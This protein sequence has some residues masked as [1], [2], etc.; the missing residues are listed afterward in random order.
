VSDHTD[1]LGPRLH[2]A[3]DPMLP[4]SEAEQRLLR[5][6]RAR[7]LDASPAGT[8]SQRRFHRT[9]AVVGVG[10]VVAALLT[11]VLVLALG[12]RTH[13]ATHTAHP[14]PVRKPLPVSS[15]P[16]KPSF[17][18]PSPAP[19]QSPAAVDYVA[20]WSVSFPDA[21]D[22]WAM[23]DGCDTQ[24]RCQ[25]AVAR[26]TEGGRTWQPVTPLPD[27]S[28]PGSLEG[29][30]AASAEDAWV[31]GDGDGGSRPVF[32]ATHDG[33]R[34]W[35]TVDTGGAEVA[36]VAVADGSIWALTACPQTDTG[37]ARCN[38]QVI[39]SPVHADAWT[40][41]G[42][43][44]AAVQGPAESRPRLVRSG[45]RAWIVRETVP[46]GETSMVRSDDGG[47]TWTAL[48]V[49][50][51]RMNSLVL[52]ASSADHVMLACAMIGAWPAPQEVWASHD[53]GVHWA[54]R[55]RSGAYGPGGSPVPDAGSLHD[56]GV[57]IQLAV[58]ADST[59]WMA[60][61]RGSVLSTGD[62][63]VGWRETS[64]PAAEFGDSG[65]TEGVVFADA[66]HGWAISAAGLWVTT[67]GGGHW[68]YQPIVGRVPGFQQ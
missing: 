15:L 2:D 19:W 5:Q 64:L 37:A 28:P 22:G 66:L 40:S 49:P 56:Q 45:T 18:M 55:S 31:W 52:G 35:H 30:A 54:L 59:A 38:V 6:L 1:D 7:V 32:R 10:L 4:R 20:P 65:G 60:C 46:G 29:I 21:R 27:A 47:R 17:A 50:C 61:E 8:T 26:T 43:P 14:L 62:D 3:L 48:T 67:D 23:G 11:G 39:A 42:T 12:L 25:A 58:T 9:F 34:T 36:S 63:G 33:G 51:D 24:Q 68:S 57:P 53:G 13:T 16:V 41:L 44:S